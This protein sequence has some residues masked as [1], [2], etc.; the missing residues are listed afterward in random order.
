MK[1]LLEFKKEASKVSFL[2][3]HLMQ[4]WQSNNHDVLALL[5]QN[6]VHDV[7][8]CINYDYVTDHNK[9]L[10][11]IKTLKEMK[12]YN[13]SC[14]VTQFICEEIDMLYTGYVVM[15]DN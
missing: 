9:C 1:N 7:S 2:L 3:A 4:V 5:L 13:K 12:V 6:L 14:P 8:E 10:A 15:A 11:I